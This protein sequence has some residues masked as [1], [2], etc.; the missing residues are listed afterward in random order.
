MKKFLSAALAALLIVLTLTSCGGKLPDN[1]VYEAADMVGK[2]VGVLRDSPSAGYI[3]PFTGVLSVRYYDNAES[4]A[5]ELKNGGI[6]CALADESTLAAM[7]KSSS[8]LHALEEKFIDRSYCIAVSVENRI[9]IENIGMA[10]SA[11]SRDGTLA[12]IVDGWLNGGYA[13]AYQN[14]EYER[15]ISVAVQPGFYPYAFYDE[16]GE[17]TGLE[18][19]IVYEICARLGLNVEFAPV[20]SER[21]LYMA[22]SGKT[23]FAIGLIVQDP[24]N[25]AISYSENYM[26]STQ[27]IVVR[28]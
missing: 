12:A 8:R 21:L 3:A 19:D 18:I 2:T 6:D 20:D 23:S 17:L 26:H 27:L 9:M 5:V 16:E 22:E 11:M 15:S 28:G 10:L 4:L 13:G 24:D 1:K 25:E 7:R 14:G